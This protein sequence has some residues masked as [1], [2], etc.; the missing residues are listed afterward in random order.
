MPDSS[1]SDRLSSLS[2]L[3]KAALLRTWR[4][5]SSND[6]P[7]DIRK[8]LM[9][10]LLAY[11]IQEQEFGPLSH[12]SRRRLIEIAST[13]GEGR[14]AS[15]RVKIKPG[16][17]LV[18]EWKHQIHVVNVEEGHYEYKGILY[19]SLSEVARL[20]TGTRWSGPRFFGLKNKLAIPP[21]EVA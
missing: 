16:T 9:V 21:K 19:A 11:R 13:T 1:I 7:A 8:E 3:N 20:I 4:E 10:Q 18:R 6:P 14:L 5:L 12:E 17:R 15:R 2:L